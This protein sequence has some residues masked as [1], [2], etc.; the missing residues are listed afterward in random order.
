MRPAK[1]K[2]IEDITESIWT[3]QALAEE[4][5]Q[6]H[7]VIR[8]DERLVPLSDAQALT[9]ALHTVKARLRSVYI[10]SLYEVQEIIWSNAEEEE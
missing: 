8:K 9:T 3:A 7:E 10:D 2:W 1:N 6:L 5:A 4:L